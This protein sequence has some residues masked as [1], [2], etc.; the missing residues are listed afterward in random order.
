MSTCSAITDDSQIKTIDMDALIK[1]VRNGG[2]IRTGIDIYNKIGALLLEKSVRVDNVKLL[3]IIKENGFDQLP[4]HPGG[5]GGIWD[6]S[7]QRIKDDPLPA[8]AP[9]P[10]SFN[11]LDPAT[12]DHL[13][14]KLFNIQALKQEASKKYLVAKGVIKQVI[15]DIKNTGGD[16]DFDLVETTVTDL[17]AFMTKSEDAFAYLTHEIFA[18]DD[19]LYNHSINVCTI[20][21]AVISRF[22]KQIDGA[23]EKGYSADEIQSIAI[24]YFLHDVGKIL[25]SENILN[26]T[27]TL[28]E[29]EFDRIKYHSFEHGAKIL[30]QNRIQNPFVENVVKYHHCPLYKTE[31]NCYPDGPFP[32]KLPAYVKICKLVDMYD[33]M[34]SK[35]CYKAARNPIAVVTELFN[36]YAGKDASLQFI[37]HC[38]IK[39]VGIFPAGCTVTLQNGQMGYV[40]DSNGPILIIYTDQNGNTLEDNPLPI[41][42]ADAPGNDPDRWIDV[43]KPL[44]EPVL[45]FSRFPSYL[46]EYFAH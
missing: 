12:P 27:S 32:G 41:D 14:Q 44:V 29:S 4:I 24:G 13:K 6:S 26:K 11:L 25:I 46:K 23:N 28:S 10:F 8:R 18:Y 30:K 38:F 42:L 2:T 37:L 35:R 19:Y 20:G 22:N 9:L 1:I 16:F 31:P 21:S 15:T 7:G 5:L 3:E 36:N 40:I 17:L 33:A 34:T 43:K 39:S 45:A